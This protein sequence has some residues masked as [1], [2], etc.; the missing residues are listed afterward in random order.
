VTDAGALH[1]RW[2]HSHEEDG[3]DEEVFRPASYAFPPA[4]G[5][6]SI[7]LR[8]DGTYV[9]RSPG[10]DDRPQESSGDW[11]LAG[12]Q[13]VVGDRRWTVAAAEKNRLLLK[14]E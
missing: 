5:R 2:V 10:P 1:G 12:D 9:E 6:S 4:R 11:S 14:P 13:L 8:P 3:D 7:E